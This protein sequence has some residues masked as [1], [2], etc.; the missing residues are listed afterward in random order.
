MKNTLPKSDNQVDLI[1]K[2]IIP[3][4]CDSHTHLVFAKTRE[5]EFEQRIAGAS[6][7]EIAQAGGGI[8]NSARALQQM[9]EDILYEKA[10]ERLHEAQYYGTGAIEIKSGYGL[11]MDAELK[12]LRVIRRLKEKANI[13][14]KATF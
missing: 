14:I 11:T 3:A 12:M 4:F 6:Y 1:G 2:W 13:P 10:L 5:N 9:N 7:E 8:Q